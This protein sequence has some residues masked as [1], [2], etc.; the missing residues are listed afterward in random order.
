[1]FAKKTVF[2]V[3][4]GAS[5][6]AGLPTGE[7][8]K[9][10]LAKM[11]RF[12]LAENG[13]I[14]DTQKKN[15]IRQYL[16]SNQIPMS[17]LNAYIDAGRRISAAMIQAPSIDSYLESQH[18]DARIVFMGK[19]TLLRGTSIVLTHHLHPLLAMLRSITLTELLAIF[20]GKRSLI[21]LSSVDRLQTFSAR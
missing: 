11:L 21:A 2:I 3:G 16:T 6:E 9:S 12:D 4:A 1:M 5:F 7:A 20:N 18:H 19:L 13:T 17:E 8:L 14:E 10:D 15:L